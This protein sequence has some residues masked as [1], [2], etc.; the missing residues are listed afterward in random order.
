MYPRV[1]FSAQQ[2][3]ELLATGKTFDEIRA[4]CDFLEI[5]DMHQVLSYA[6][7]LMDHG[8]PAEVEVAWATE[9]GRRLEAILDGSQPG[10]S[11]AEVIERLGLDKPGSTT[12]RDTRE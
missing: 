4:D 10:L 2:L 3:L 9:I 6:A 8:D 7:T 11:D 12:S 1:R 5:D